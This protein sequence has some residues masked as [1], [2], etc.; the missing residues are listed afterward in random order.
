MERRSIFDESPDALAA[1]FN[2]CF[3]DYVVEVNLD[4]P[5]VA[6]WAR[7]RAGSRPVTQQ[8][9]PVQ[10]EVFRLGPEARRLCDAFDGATRLDDALASA[11]DAHAQA[12]AGRIA[13]LLFETGL[14]SF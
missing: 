14:A 11:G 12:R 4:G 2:R 8:D 1:L 5:T 7:A 9:P 6:G 13:Y 10:P 3:E